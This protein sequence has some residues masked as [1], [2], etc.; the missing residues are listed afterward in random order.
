MYGRYFVI[1]SRAF[2]YKEEALRVQ[3]LWLEGRRAE[4]A[5]AVPDAM[6]QKTGIIGTEAMVRERIRNY[7]DAGVTTLRVDP[8]GATLDDKLL[9]LE[10]VIGMVRDVAI[11][12]ETATA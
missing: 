3:S 2:G 10:K 12:A 8:A 1:G 6:V 11:P 4:A 9:L 7:Q 5:E